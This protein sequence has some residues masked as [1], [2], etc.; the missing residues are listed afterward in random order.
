MLEA[1]HVGIVHRD[2][3]PSNLFLAVDDGVRRVKVTSKPAEAPKEPR[4]SPPPP[5]AANNPLLL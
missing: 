4:K 3:K 5:A 1:H 2:L